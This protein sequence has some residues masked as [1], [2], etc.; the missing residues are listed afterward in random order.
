MAVNQDVAALLLDVIPLAIR[1]LRRDLKRDMQKNLKKN[2]DCLTIVQFRILTS[3]YY[4]A[5]NNKSIAEAVGLS[6][7]ATSRAL[8]GLKKRG[9]IE[10]R[11]A[12]QDKR[13]VLVSLS[14]QGLAKLEE[15][16]T[17]LGAGMSARMKSVTPNKVKKA[18]SGL[19]A[20]REILVSLN[21][22]DT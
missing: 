10:S 14:R 6:V 11:K 15:A 17:H 1:E 4:D 9:L 5:M 20:L 18:Q 21:S 13:E 3:L 2:S 7:P 19:L 22:A 12:K 8:V 16:R